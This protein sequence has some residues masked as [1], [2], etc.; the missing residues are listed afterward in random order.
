MLLNIASL[1]MLNAALHLGHVKTW[2]LAL[3]QP[4]PLILG[5]FAF[6][7]VSKGSFLYITT[8]F[9][10]DI[11]HTLGKLR[12]KTRIPL[13]SEQKAPGTLASAASK[14]CFISMVRCKSSQTWLSWPHTLCYYQF[15]RS[16]MLDT[17]NS[18]GKEPISCEDLGRD[19][20]LLGTS[21]LTMQ[22]KVAHRCWLWASCTFPR[23]CSYWRQGGP[24]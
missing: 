15:L 2:C 20:S 11:C 19:A 16:F 4:V 18:K 9:A 17:R 6:G 22:L 1:K 3:G 10:N 14:K 24:Y 7:W 13:K 5:C 21:R 23:C 12:P 8:S